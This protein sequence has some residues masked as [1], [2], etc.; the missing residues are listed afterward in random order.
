MFTRF[1]EFL[2]CDVLVSCF[3]FVASMFVCVCCLVVVVVFCLG[4]GG[5]CCLLCCLFVCCGLF[6]LCCVCGCDV[7]LLLFVARVFGVL[8]CCGLLLRVMVCVV[9]FCCFVCCALLICLSFVVFC[10]LW[11]R[12][13]VSGLCA[14]FRVR[15]VVVCVVS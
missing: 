12:A 4:G 15:V 10:L 9:C 11:F 8:C 1:V 13:G 2:F 5:L 3:V 7:F 6:V 14:L